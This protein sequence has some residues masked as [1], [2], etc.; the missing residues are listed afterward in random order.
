MEQ[1]NTI[2]VDSETER[3]N[4]EQYVLGGVFNEATMKETVFEFQRPL[5]K[6]ERS[7]LTDLIEQMQKEQNLLNKLK[8]I[9]EKEKQDNVNNQTERTESAN[10][11]VS[12][13][14]KFH[15][16]IKEKNL[17]PKVTEE[18]PKEQTLFFKPKMAPKTVNGITMSADGD[19]ADQNEEIVMI[20]GILTHY[21]IQRINEFRKELREIDQ[22]MNTTEA[23]DEHQLQNAKGLMQKY[24]DCKNNM[25]GYV[26]T[27][28][29]NGNI[30][31]FPQKDLQKE[32]MQVQQKNKEKTIKEEKE[33]EKEQEKTHGKQL[34]KEMPSS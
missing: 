20:N 3:K 14:A 6:E 4:K 21:D 15:D 16:Y 2:T 33:K 30:R 27:Y 12:L 23:M 18:T 10:R 5:N 24:N 7:S 32:I 11:L 26:N 31:T 25:S 28:I 19:M 29:K 8:E 17:L 34:R 13:F 9:R 1:E 22:Q